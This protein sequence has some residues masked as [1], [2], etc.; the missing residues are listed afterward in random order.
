MNDL[1]ANVQPIAIVRP[2]WRG[3]LLLSPDGFR[4]ST[5]G[6]VG[7]AVGIPL[8]RLRGSTFGTLA[9]DDQQRIRVKWKPLD[10]DHLLK[11]DTLTTN[12]GEWSEKLLV[13]GCPSGRF[14]FRGDYQ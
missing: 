13:G 14:K 3:P 6:W 4:L 12:G 8:H 2:R 9:K 11:L 7:M 1:E 5:I 10:I